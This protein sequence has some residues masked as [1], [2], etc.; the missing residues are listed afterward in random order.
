MYPVHD[1]IDYFAGAWHLSRRIFDHRAGQT[2]RLTGLA[3]FT[4]R[5]GGLDY[6][7]AGEM[8]FGAY[9]GQASQ[10]YHWDMVDGSRA[11]VQFRDGR[12]FH[13]LDLATG[14]AT[15]EHLC[16][17]DH[18]RGRFRILD[19]DSWQTVW[20]VIGPRKNLILANRFR[21]IETSSIAQDPIA[22]D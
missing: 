17:A 12:F 16:A 13:A 6:A 10:I 8:T 11:K 1:L 14:I 20:Q 18:Y 9:Q 19:A 15:I 7:E 2:G 21:R 4:P 5:L 22:Q 3:R